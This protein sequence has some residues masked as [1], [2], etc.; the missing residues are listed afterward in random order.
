[1]ANLV[2]RKDISQ[3]IVHKCKSVNEDP[4]I[5]LIVNDETWYVQPV[6]YHWRRARPNRYFPHPLWEVGT[7]YTNCDFV[8]LV[9]KLIHL[10]TRSEFLPSTESVRK[11]VTDAIRKGNYTIEDEDSRQIRI[12]LTNRTLDTFQLTKWYAVTFNQIQSAVKKQVTQN[13]QR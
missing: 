7:I 5:P 12:G 9:K 8:N 4:H 10:T 13:A 1:V 3:R 2:K 11:I 6:V